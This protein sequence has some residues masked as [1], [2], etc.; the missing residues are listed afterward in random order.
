MATSATKLRTPLAMMRVTHQIQFTGK[1]WLT[2][3][4]K[5]KERGSRGVRLD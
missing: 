2:A 1:A 4:A 3:R 5:E